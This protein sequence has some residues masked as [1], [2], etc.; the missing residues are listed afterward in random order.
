MDFMG[1]DD[2]SMQQGYDNY[3]MQQGYCGYDMQGQYQR[4]YNKAEI[5][6]GLIDYLSSLGVNITKVEMIE[7]EPN[8][9]RH[10]CEPVGVSGLTFSLFPVMQPFGVVQVKYWCCTACGKLFVSKFSLDSV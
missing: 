8:V 10:A 9:L 2:Y 5:R 4:K 6:Q 3:G 1:C 7:D